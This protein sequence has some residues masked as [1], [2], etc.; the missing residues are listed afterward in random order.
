M[1]KI[2]TMFM[3]YEPHIHDSVNDLS[4]FRFT[5]MTSIFV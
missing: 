1:T 2:G 4:N 3:H 5:L